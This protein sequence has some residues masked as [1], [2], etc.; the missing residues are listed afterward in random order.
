M[1]RLAVATVLTFATSFS[2]FAA[3]EK[4][5][6][7]PKLNFMDHVLPIFR[8]HCLKCHNANEA[9]GGLAIDSYAALMEGGGSGE[10]VFEGDAASSRLY[11]LMIHEDTP[12]MP[13]NQDP[14][15]KAKLD[16]IKDW[17]D[18][19]VLENSGSKRKKKKG[20]SL[21]FASLD[22]GGKPSEIVM[23]ESVWRVP[24][25]ASDR[26][27]AASALATSPWAPLVAVGGQRQV[28][29]YNTDTNK[30]AGIIPY[31][32]GIPQALQFSVDGSYLLVAGGTHSSIGIAAVYDVR[33]GDRI[34]KVGDELDTVFGADMND[35]MSRIAL[36]GPQRMLRIYDTASGEAVFELKKHTDWIYCV[37]Y[38]P[39][40]ILVASGDRSGGL[41]VW[42]ADTG[43][44]YLDLVGHKGAI[45]G[46]SW[47]ADSNVLVSASEDGTVKMWEMT[48]GKLLKSFNA[49]GGGATGIMMAKDGRMVTS[50]K[51]RTVKLWKSDG[52]GLATFPAFGEPALEA[53]ISHDGSK[54]IG[55]DWSGRTVMWNAS[56]SK[57]STEL[58]ANP[59][60]LDA[61]KANLSSSILAMEKTLSAAIAKEAAQQKV[62]DASTNAFNA[63]TKSLADAKAALKKA[64]SDRASVNK[65]LA[66]LNA[67][68]TSED[69]KL[70]DLNAKIAALAKQIQEASGL[71]NSSRKEMEGAIVRRDTARKEKAPLLAALAETRKEKATAEA[72]MAQITAKLADLTM[73]ESALVTKENAAAEQEKT[74]E[75]ER[76]RR[77]PLSPRRTKR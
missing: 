61:Q 71:V 31:P 64:D 3:D 65:V 36:G 30:L 49:H 10:V 32:E 6:E 54:V 67:Q 17:I 12:V 69:K 52:G 74:A 20:P 59:P 34:L 5:T 75:K 70:N 58:S 63:K 1:K 14:I 72:G 62:V 16:I 23:P 77:M 50:G 4:A 43:R 55:G 29:L 8:Q 11:Q 37:D 35:N 45:R 73:R 25:V 21:S 47:R 19:G 46:I 18:G 42:E 44:L 66:S 26:A 51:D 27:A 2:L 40:G 24:V 57:I 7:S 13:P 22:A 39:D 38:S 53:V 41:H 56:D 9:K 28:A 76:L 15:E 68:K 33:T 48:N 60:T